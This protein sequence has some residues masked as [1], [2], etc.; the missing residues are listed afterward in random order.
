M[1]QKQKEK[2]KV[3]MA[4]SIALGHCVC[5]PAK[6]CP[7]PLFKEKD[8]CQCAGEKLPLEI[9]GEI[10]LTDYVKSAGCASKIGK[11][12]LYDILS[13]VPAIDDDRVLV[14]SNAGD[15]AGVILLSEDDTHAHIL[16]VD[17]FAPS[18]DDPY[19]FGQIAAANSVSDVYAMGGKPQAALSIV[20]F[21]VEILPNDV[22]RDILRGGI[23]KMKEAGVPV[24]GGHSIKDGEI[25]C[26]FAVLGTCPKDGFVRNSGAEVGDIMILTKPLGV[27]I[28]AFAG[29]IG[30]ATPE[31][32][33]KVAESMST[34]NK[35]AAEVMVA[36][37][38]HAATDITGYSLLGHLAEIVKN[39]E[40]EVEI[41]FEKIPL[42]ENVA[43]FAR[44][45]ILPG[46]VERNRES[47]S[48]EVLN[49]S[50]LADAQKNI[51]FSPETSGG[52]LMFIPLANAEKTLEELHKRGVASASVIGKVTEKNKKGLITV[53]TECK[54]DYSY[55]KP[56][57]KNIPIPTQEE[58]CC[59]CEEE[60]H[61]EQS[62]CSEN[63]EDEECC[64]S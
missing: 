24:V 27:G 36:N 38:V 29:Q 19:T 57:K 45:E 9:D 16:T 41:D 34:L 25:K 20:G 11:K 17:V 7:C 61:S 23:E 4:R 59:C 46:A 60:E 15:D 30:H 49:L 32:L 48:E 8:V 22:M 39:S 18:V 6:P 5:D 50:K 52:L 62:C 33:A 40:V 28:T 63:K 43:K 14:G 12:D 54:D 10:K 26:G 21:P 58:P 37:D 51:L 55:I 64:C 13:G 1:N 56:V 3:I 47:V 53:T 2:R 44:E 35:D 42:F 31:N